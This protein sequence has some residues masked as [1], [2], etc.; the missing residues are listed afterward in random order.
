MNQKSDRSVMMERRVRILFLVLLMTGLAGPLMASPDRGSTDRPRIGL[1][2]SGGGARGAAHVGVLKVIDELK[3]PIDVVTGTSMGAII[4]GLYASGMSALEIEKALDEVDWSDVLKDDTIRTELSFRRKEQDKDFIRRS[5]VGVRD[6]TV[7]LPFGVL[8]GQKLLLLLKKLT[9]PVSGVGDFDRLAIPFRAVATDIVTGKAVVIGKGDLALAMRAS[10]S[11]PSIFSAVEMDGKLLVDGGV[12]NNLPVEVARDMGAELLIVVDISTP[13]Y[14]REQIRSALSV[15]DQLTTIMTRSNTERSIALLTDRDIFMVPELGDLGTG[16]FV[17]SMQA[18]PLGEQAAR[19]VQ[20]R[21]ATLAVDDGDW[22]AYLQRRQQLQNDA[23]EQPV[24]A[25]V[26]IDNDSGI[27]DELLVARLGLREGEPLDLQKLREGIDRI[28]G[29][30]LFQSVSYR[31]VEEEGEA[32]LVLEV[33]E[34]S[35]GPGF[36]DMGLSFYGNFEGNTLSLG[37][38]YTRTAVNPLGG[39]YRLILRLGDNYSA[40]AEF[41]QPLSVE[42]PFFVNPKVEARRRVIG[43]YEE[44]RKVAEYSFSQARVA[45]EGGKELGNWGEVRVGYQ[46][47]YDDIEVDIGAPDLDEAQYREGKVFLQLAVDTADS[48]FFPTRGQFGRVRYQ[49]YHEALGG[50][51][52]FQ[53]VMGRWLGAYSRGRNV[54][55][56]HARAAYTFDSNAPIYGHQLLGGFLNLSGYDRYE[57]SGQHLGYGFVGFHRR[58]NAFTSLVPIYLGGTLEAGNVWQSSGDFGRSWIASG[59]LFL[60]LDTFLGPLYLG[61]GIAENDHQ[62]IFFHLGVPY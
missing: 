57:L 27:S 3:I 47:A 6:G 46:Y 8:Q 55:L 18:V 62:N 50:D 31:L 34:K 39:E 7:K 41:Y 15:A 38:G 2:L 37:A 49:L 59:S 10:A 12:S 36:L 22:Q 33:R 26:H 52:D 35:W 58:L 25:F 42:E 29:M 54:L 43:F 51:H 30:D 28:Y 16:D 20:E 44:N 45:L 23:G 19:A 21:L 32:G 53:Q 61:V 24:L 48:P 14:S 40:F 4:G 60:G 9:R 1:V 56:L 13:L 5:V 17:Q 11:I